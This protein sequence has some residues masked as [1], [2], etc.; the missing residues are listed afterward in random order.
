MLEISRE[1]AVLFLLSLLLF[2]VLVLVLIGNSRYIC[3]LVSSGYVSTALQKLKKREKRT[4]FCK[5]ASCA[6]MNMSCEK[7]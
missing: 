7:K 3:N 4:V 5:V 6:C 2:L 1:K